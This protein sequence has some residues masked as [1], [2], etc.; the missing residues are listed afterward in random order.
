MRKGDIYLADLNPTKGAEINKK[1]P[2]LVFQNN[3]AC[4]HGQTVT[5]LPISSAQYKK[6]IFEIQIKANKS[7]R[8]MT[9][10]KVL[11]HQIR[12]IDK[13]RLTKK[14]GKTTDKILIETESKL[15]LHLGIT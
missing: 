6:R 8:L 13:Q 4:D 14:I 9:D 3:I 12:T 1:R 5:I 11:V 7:N 2:V 15:K 10:S